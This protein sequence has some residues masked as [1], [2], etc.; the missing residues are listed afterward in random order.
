MRWLRVL[1]MVFRIVHGYAL[2]N[3]KLLHN[4]QSRPLSLLID[5]NKL[6]SSA[7]TLKSLK[8]EVIYTEV[9]KKSK[10]IVHA[11]PCQNIDE[12]LLYLEKVKDPKASHNCWAY[13]SIKTQRMS[14]DGE[15]SS[16]AGKP[17]YTAIESMQ[18]IDTMVVITRYFG[19]IKLGTGGLIRAYHS[20]AKNALLQAKIIVHIPYKRIT[21]YTT[22]LYSGMLYY[23]LDQYKQSS[24]ETINVEENN[25]NNE[26]NRNFAIACNIAE[27]DVN[28]VKSM[29]LDICKGNVSIAIT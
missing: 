24:V 11:A 8:E 20:A 6:T 29:L 27:N 3:V 9:V 14:D 7:D 10:F 12:A 25:D 22:S 4:H 13:R 21:I 23:A 26:N 5:A 19:G 1:L 28:K 17:I 15:P 16:T 2:H 18:L